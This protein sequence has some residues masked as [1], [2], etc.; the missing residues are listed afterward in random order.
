MLPYELLVLASY[1]WIGFLVSSR[2][3]LV[4]NG[5]SGDDLKEVLAE[6]F[7]QPVEVCFIIILLRRCLVDLCDSG[8]FY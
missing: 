5:Y 7:Q 4:G 3:K 2:S 1:L 6:N 8:Y